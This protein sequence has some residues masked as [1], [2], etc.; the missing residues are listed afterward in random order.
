MTTPRRRSLRDVS[1]VVAVVGLVAASCSSGTGN[2]AVVVSGS[3]ASV[4]AETPADPE[5]SVGAE[6]SS[7]A[8]EELVV[9]TAI[10]TPATAA[11]QADRYPD[12]KDPSEVVTRTPTAVG[13]GVSP[14][15]FTTVLATVTG[16]DGEECLV[17]LWL[18]DTAEERGRGLMGVT[19][20]GGPV[21]M[22]FTWDEPT[23]GR[24]YMFDTP[25]P[26]AIA[27]FAPDGS[28]VAE[29]DMTPC[30]D[31]PAAECERYGPDVAY[32]VAVE[33][34]EGQLGAVGIAAG[35]R[36]AVDVSTEAPTCPGV[37]G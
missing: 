9:D 33:M 8:T 36:I 29:A 7:V 35:S 34:F 27:W 1:T 15:G 4:G 2:E 16:A 22:A 21:G 24:F 18:A 20:L 37:S 17:C 13:D 14:E 12:L 5:T 28:W 11:E 6:T 23:D 32:D 30:L 10:T 26:L 19:D 3:E 31:R 25:T